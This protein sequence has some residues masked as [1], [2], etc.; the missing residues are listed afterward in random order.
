VR[1][2]LMS[3]VLMLA[4][5]GGGSDSGDSANNSEQATPAGDQSSQPMNPFQPTQ[6]PPTVAPVEDEPAQQPLPTEPDSASPEPGSEPLAPDMPVA[7][8]PED[9]DPLA[10]PQAPGTD[11]GMDPESAPVAPPVAPSSAPS[12]TGL[13]QLFGRVTFDVQFFGSADTLQFVVDFSENDVERDRT[14]TQALVA[15][16]P[17]PYDA[18]SCFNFDEAPQDYGCFGFLLSGEVNLFVFRLEGGMGSGNFEQCSRDEGDLEFCVNDFVQSPDGFVDVMVVPVPA[19]SSEVT[20]ASQLSPGEFQAMMEVQG[21]A[22]R[23]DNF[24]SQELSAEQSALV[25]TMQARIAAVLE[26]QR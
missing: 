23:S 15:S 22:T 7:A 5:C 24:V 8:A 12:A 14:G 6:Q 25:Q 11:P 13:S 9:T 19:P 21:Q 3:S 18:F 16:R 10:P 17:S 4:A 20:T 2:A 1:L 26:A